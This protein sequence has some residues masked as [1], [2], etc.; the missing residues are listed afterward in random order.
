LH[1]PTKPNTLT[2]FQGTNIRLCDLKSSTLHSIFNIHALACI[3]QNE[4]TSSYSFHDKIDCLSSKESECF[5][6]WIR[7]YSAKEIA[8]KLQRSHRTVEIHLANIKQKI[9]LQKKSQIIEW[10]IHNQAYAKIP[11]GLTLTF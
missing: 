9:G 3:Q 7:G 10:S 4:K 6:Y 8:R 5:F 11:S 2:I 1:D